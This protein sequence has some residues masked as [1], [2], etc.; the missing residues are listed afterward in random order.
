MA[1]G[2]VRWLHLGDLHASDE[3]GWESVG[4]LSRI[5][6]EIEAN[7]PAG[8]LHFAYL[9]GDNAHHGRP[10]QYRRI[11]AA[12][13]PL[14]LP[15][16]VIPGDHDFEPGHLEA[17]RTLSGE[18]LA[19]VVD[20]PTSIALGDRRALFLDIVSA[21][22]GG[23]DF[24]L[25]DAH[26]DWLKAEFDAA[27]KAREAGPIVF[28][29]AFP[30]DLKA[31]GEAMAK[32]FADAGVAFVD[33]GH[34]HYNEV[35]NDGA[36]IYAATRS[37]GQ[38]EEGPFGFS[39][40]AVDGDGASWRFKAADSPW[41][42]VMITSPVDERLSVDRAAFDPRGG[43]TV[44]A[45]VLGQDVSGVEVRVDGGESLAMAAV[46]AEVGM[47]SAAVGPVSE[48][49]HTIRVLAHGGSGILAHDEIVV[50]FPAPKRKPSVLGT[51]DSRIGAWPEHGL[52]GTRL[53]PNANGR[54]W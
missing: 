32:M 37:T 42:W 38:V 16:Y 12:L 51:H 53:G 35:L 5:V 49:R 14:S 41:P 1:P 8:A 50:C 23:P 9:P 43:L 33:T 10:E 48:G 45:L 3:D 31:G 6:E 19:G 39:I 44:R 30:G 17:F 34:T 11:E 4:R 52:L 7:V 18:T 40:A 21:G 29:H 54:E 13:A 20:R 15:V 36:V 47:W 25:A 22:S 26:L 27:A 46:P 2:C 28:M 24:R